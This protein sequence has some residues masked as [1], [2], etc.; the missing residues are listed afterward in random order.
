M[1]INFKKRVSNIVFL[2]KDVLDAGN[3]HIFLKRFVMDLLYTAVNI[4]IKYL[5]T[6]LN[7]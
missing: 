3:Y 4:S 5:L 2:K 7:V 1:K 6:K